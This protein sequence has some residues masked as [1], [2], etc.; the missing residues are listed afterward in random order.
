MSTRDSSTQ[1]QIRQ[2]RADTFLKGATW[3]AETDSTNSQSLQLLSANTSVPTPHLVFAENQY[4]GRGRGSNTWWS[5]PGSLTFSVIVD[6]SQLGLKNVDRPLLPLLTGMAVL[7]AVKT[8]LPEQSLGL[9]W[10]N[11]VFF[12]KRKLG[13][14]LIEVTGAPCQHAVVGVG[15]N[16]NNSFVNAPPLLQETG[17]ALVDCLDQSCDSI[18]VLRQ[19][20]TQFEIVIEQQSKTRDALEDWSK[21]CILRGKH[22]VLGAG[23]NDVRGVCAGIDATGALLLNTDAGQQRFVGGVVKSWQ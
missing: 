7:R 19:F 15:L 18:D 23:T 10:P 11:D 20:L 16:V 14:V 22:V 3:Y 5:G 4:A 6:F 21:Y 1:T 8:L 12:E 2:L 13:G 9:K 17:I